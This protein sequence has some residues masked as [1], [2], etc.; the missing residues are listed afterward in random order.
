MPL[1][2][3]TMMITYY[4]FSYQFLMLAQTN[5]TYE[6]AHFSDAILIASLMYFNLKAD[7]SHRSNS[8]PKINHQL[9]ANALHYHHQ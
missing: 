1:I 2:Q 4:Y 3:Y 9:F 7:F 6:H 8:L 5:A